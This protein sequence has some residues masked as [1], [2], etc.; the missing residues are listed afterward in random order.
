[1]LIFATVVLGTLVVSP[2]KITLIRFRPCSTL[3]TVIALECEAG[4][5][6]PS[7]HSERVFALATILRG[8]GR[9]RAALLYILAA[10]VAFSRVYL[11]VHYPL[12]IFVGSLIGLIVGKVTLR[13]EKRM[14]GTTYQFIKPIHG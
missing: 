4:S 8:K 11:G 2:L 10:T 9:K 13:L 6:F 1:M 14:V 3:P 5:S 12:D 7:G